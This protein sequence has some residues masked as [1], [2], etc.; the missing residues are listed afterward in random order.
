MAPTADIAATTTPVPPATHT[1]SPT[2]PAVLDTPDAPEASRSCRSTTSTATAS[3]SHTKASGGHTTAVNTPLEKDS[4]DM[5]GSPVVPKEDVEKAALGSGAGHPSD[6]SQTTLTSSTPPD[7]KNPH[8]KPHHLSKTPSTSRPSRTPAAGG[9]SLQRMS[10]A[11]TVQLE[12]ELRRHVSLHGVRSHHEGGQVLE[13]RRTLDRG[14]GEEEVVI[15]DW[16]PGDPSHPLNWSPVR[17]YAILATT[18]FITFICAANVASTAVLATWGTEWYGV[19]REAFILMQSVPMIALAIAPLVLA[20]LSETLGR[21]MIYHVTSLLV[22]IL[23]C[24]L[25]WSRSYA[26]CLVTRFFQG[27][28][29]SVSN[30]MVGGTVADLF[31]AKQRGTAMGLFTLAIFTG[32]GLGITSV[33]W[34]GQNLG[35]RWGYGVQ[36]IVSLVSVGLNFLVLRETRADVLISWRAKKLTKETGIVHIAAGDVEKVDM[37]TMMKISLVRPLQYLFTEP[38][39]TA[40]SAWIGFAWACVFLGGSSILLVFEAYGFSAAQ[41]ASVEC[42]MAIGAIIGF[43]SLFHQE[44]LFR[45][46]ARKHNGRA[47]PEARLYWA[48]YGG[49]LFPLSMYIYAWTGQAGKVHWAVPAVMLVFWNWGVF[50]MY[51]GVFTYLADAYE[52]YSSSAQAAQ[53][54]C[55]NFLSGIFPL[56]GHQMYVAMGYPHASTLVASVALALAAAPILLILFGKKLRAR[57]KVTSAL[58]KDE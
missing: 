12:D 21:N 35:F 44:Y 39:V 19:S 31:Q 16:V 7:P 58:F 33:A 46:S 50:C 24:P 48:A 51:S 54:F 40:L 45:R 30:S 25:I 49:L 11:R 10:S 15:I 14:K 41:A 42:T 2:D 22:S 20:P 27:A 53:S 38:I 18:C 17:K 1:S 34:C 13:A 43:C 9:G 3:S 26:G 47:P 57:S 52:T 55:R 5:D 32:Q 37:K 4:N 28:A 23:Y 6:P 36:A 29:M 8:A 56:F